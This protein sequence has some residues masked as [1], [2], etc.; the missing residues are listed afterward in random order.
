MKSWEDVIDQSGHLI[1][2]TYFINP[3]IKQDESKQK[4]NTY[5]FSKH[6][7]HVRH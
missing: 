5:Y 3:K 6:V 2:H 1:K 4:D 7:P